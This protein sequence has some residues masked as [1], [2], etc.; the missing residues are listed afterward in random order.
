MQ[1]QS[2][3]SGGLTAEQFRALSAARL[4]A[5]RVR[6][7]AGIAAFSGWSMVI[8]AAMTM[9]GALLGSMSSLAIGVCLGLIAWRELCGARMLWRMDLRG[10]RLLGFN[11]VVLGALIVLYSAWSF[12]DAMT[13]P[14]LEALGGST[15]DARM[16]KLVAELSTM[17]ALWLYSTLAV[18][19]VVVP[20]LTAWY[21]FSRARY[22]Q[23]LRAHTPEWVVETLRI[24]A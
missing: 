7:A 14:P 24:A 13:T 6:R 1:S 16:D 10:P 2:T 5:G 3:N 23:E 11:Q 20:G 12:L 8:F 15:G 17:V 4:G 9:L 22:L 18:V 19:G 21:Y